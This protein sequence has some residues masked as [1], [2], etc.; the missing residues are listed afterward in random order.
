[1]SRKQKLIEARGTAIA[2]M[3]ALQALAEQEEREL[4]QEE[5]TEFEARTSEVQGI[6]RQIRQAE[7]LERLSSAMHVVPSGQDTAGT[8]E[9]RMFDLA[10][11]GQGEHV[12]HNRDYEVRA[13]VKGTG[14]PAG[15]TVNEGVVDVLIPQLVIE[16]LGATVYTNYY[17]RKL[18][19]PSLLPDFASP[20]DEIE[21]ADEKEIT[22]TEVPLTPRRFAVSVPISNRF[23]KSDSVGATNYVIA[24]ARRFLGLKIESVMFSA[25]A[26]TAK[27]P[28]GLFVKA[29]ALDA[30][31]KTDM[32]A[33]LGEARG[34]LTNAGVIASQISMLTTAIIENQMTSDRID[35]GSGMMVVENGRVA[36]YGWPVLTSPYVKKAADTAVALVGDFS[37]LH[38]VQFEDI[39]MIVDP[40]SRAGTAETVYH[41]NVDVD[42]VLG[43][44][45][46]LL[47]VHSIGGAAAAAASRKKE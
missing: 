19:V 27:S 20:L 22:F 28:E 37:Y 46:A 42:W 16:R 8:A 6:D 32:F 36:K 17:D 30:T 13:V 7:E 43:D 26:G 44:D 45:K 23:L 35:P 2:R 33:L 14:N 40:Y 41:F 39:T 3:Q 29:G 34:V 4:S 1:M 9:R 11:F 5:Q 12:L 25:A 15:Q 21:Q 18:S 47:G 10:Q 24:Q 31:G 38:F